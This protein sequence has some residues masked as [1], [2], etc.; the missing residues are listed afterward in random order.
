MAMAVERLI[1]S[2]FPRDEL[3]VIGFSDRAREIKREHLPNLS[4]MECVYGT[5][6]QAGFMRARQLLAKHSTANKQII[7]VSDG[8]PTAHLHDRGGVAFAYPPVEQLSSRT[9]ID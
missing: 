6:M 5:N 8:E 3:Y 1:H 2:Q 9:V 7:M 4:S